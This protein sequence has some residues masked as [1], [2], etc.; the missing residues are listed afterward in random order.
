MRTPVR[1]GVVHHDINK[2][3][4]KPTDHACAISHLLSISPAVRGLRLRAPCGFE[5][6]R[7]DTMERVRD[8]SFCASVLAIA[9]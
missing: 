8:V 7:A 1:V 3:R 5:V 4:E 6:R 9:R 2:D